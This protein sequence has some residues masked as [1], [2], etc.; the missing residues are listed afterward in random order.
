MVAINIPDEWEVRSIHKGDDEVG[1][2]EGVEFSTVV[3]QQ[4][5]EIEIF[6]DGT[7]SVWS[8]GPHDGWRE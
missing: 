8:M 6:A 5:I 1:K 7:F 4:Y 3:N 2:T